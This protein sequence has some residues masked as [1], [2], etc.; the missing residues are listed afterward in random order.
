MDNYDY[1]MHGR[2]F[3][4]KYIENQR[5]EVQTSFGGLLMRIRGEQ[6]H[7]EDFTVDMK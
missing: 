2:V 3:G 6:A 5:I 7:L 4:V 1:V